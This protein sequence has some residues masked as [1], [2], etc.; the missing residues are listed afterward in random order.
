MSR[1]T[2]EECYWRIFDQQGADGISKMLRAWNVLE[3]IIDYSGLKQFEP[4][5]EAVECLTL[6]E[7]RHSALDSGPPACTLTDAR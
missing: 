6:M 5:P 7:Q 1:P 4:G 2:G 3:L